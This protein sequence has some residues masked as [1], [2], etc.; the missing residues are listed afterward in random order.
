[1]PLARPGPAALLDTWH[2]ACSAQYVQR[3]SLS[4]CTP[5]GVIIAQICHP[6]GGRPRL[7]PACVLIGIR[8]A[9]CHPYGQGTC[10][11]MCSDGVILRQQKDSVYKCPPADRGRYKWKGCS[12]CS[13]HARAV[14]HANQTQ[15]FATSKTGTIAAARERQTHPSPAQAGHQGVSAAP[16]AISSA[17]SSS[18]ASESAGQGINGFRVLNYAG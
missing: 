1:V 18:A 7:L 8:Q 11:S 12:W 4:F 17:S 15:T 6:R 13:M 14:A 9:P 2:Q 5:S 3:Q 16:A 10:I